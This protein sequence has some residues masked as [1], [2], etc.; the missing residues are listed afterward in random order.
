M[1]IGTI[2]QLKQAKCNGLPINGHIVAST[3]D[4]RWVVRLLGPDPAYYVDK[5][6]QTLSVN[7]IVCHP[8][9]LIEIPEKESK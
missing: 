7:D 5:F 4:R 3:S 6:N 2:V 9:S 8:D 1:T